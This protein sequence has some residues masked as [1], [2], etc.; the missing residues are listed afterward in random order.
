MKRFWILLVIAGW[1]ACLSAA[2][3]AEKT[4]AEKP[5][6]AGK[7]AAKTAA[8]KTAAKTAAK[9]AVAEKTTAAKKATEA[10]KTTADEETAAPVR[11]GVTLLKDARAALKKWERVP[12]DQAEEAAKI[13]IALYDDLK[14]D[15][16]IG[17]YARANMTETVRKKLGKLSKQIARNAKKQ[18]REA[19]ADE[20]IPE[21]VRLPEGREE[22]AAQIGGGGG[23][24]DSDV[25]NRTAQIAEAHGE[26]LAGLIQD[27]IEP[28]SWEANGGNGT[29]RFWNVQRSLIIYQTEPVHEKI[30]GTLDQLRRASN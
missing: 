1:V 9:A 22:V 7:T 10:E 3:G 5:A 29:I 25:L 30:G 12:N 26:E 24:L 21:T 2:A 19:K 4:A 23:N 8:G 17:K 15:T 28:D 16:Q 13:F 18:R 27:L 20:E 14:A 11:C 6:A